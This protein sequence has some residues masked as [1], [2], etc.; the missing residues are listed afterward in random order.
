M[1]GT[2]DRELFYLIARENAPTIWEEA[3]RA[4]SLAAT[5]EDS[6]P[7]NN[8]GFLKEPHDE[9]YPCAWI[10][11]RMRPEARKAILDHVNKALEENGYP[12]AGR[13]INYSVYGSGASYNWDEDGDFD[14]QMWVDT[15]KFNEGKDEPMTED[16]LV[17]DI[18]RIVQLVN[19]PSFKE[20]GL[21][22]EKSDGNMLIQYYAKPGQGTKEENLASKPYACFDLETEDWYQKPEPITPDFYGE[23]FILLEPKAKDIAMQASAV[24]ESLE[25]NIVEWSFWS[26]MYE[27][28]SDPRF[29]SKADDARKDAER[30]KE[31]AHN[32]FL[33]VFQGRAKAYSPEGEGYN[34]ERDLMEKLLEVW[35]IFQRLRHAVK[36]A[37]PWEEQEL[38]NELPTEEDQTPDGEANTDPEKESKSKQSKKSLKPHWHIVAAEPLKLAETIHKI[39]KDG[40]GTFN[41][42]LSP[43]NYQDGYYASVYGYNQTVSVDDFGEAS[44]QGYLDAVE[45]HPDYLIGAWV[46]DGIV[47]LDL[48]KHIPDRGE[49]IEFG[50]YNRQQAIWDIVKDEAV[51]LD[52]ASYEP[53]PAF[54]K[55][56]AWKDLMEKAK[57]LK[58]QGRVHILNNQPDHVIGRVE[59]DHGTYTTQIW[60]QDPNSRAITMW[61]CECPW[62]QYAWQRTRQWKK[63]EGRPCSHTLALFWTAQQTAAQQPQVSPDQM[64]LPGMGQ[65]PTVPPPAPYQPGAPY[66]PEGLPPEQLPHPGTEPVL[67]RGPWEPT[68]QQPL[69]P[70]VGPP[71][72]PLAPGAQPVP[73][74]MQIDPRL[75]R[76]APG[77][78]V[79]PRFVPPATPSGTSHPQEQEEGGNFGFPGAFSKVTMAER[80]GDPELDALIEGFIQKNPTLHPPTN[81]PWKLSPVQVQD[82]QDREKAVNTCS[83]AA[84]SFRA[85]LRE[86][87][88]FAEVPAATTP[89]WDIP[90]D[91]DDPGLHCAV[92][93]HRPRGQTYM[94]D[95]SSRQFPDVQEWPLVM[96]IAPG[97]SYEQWEGRDYPGFGEEGDHE[98]GELDPYGVWEDKWSMR[99]SAFENGTIVRAE[100]PLEGVD[101]DGRQWRVPR[102]SKGEVLSSDE[103][104]TIAIFPLNTGPLEPHLVRVNAETSAFSQSH[105]KP[106]IGR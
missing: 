81:N 74:G 28:H 25:R 106:F 33:N 78:Q 23:W 83:L 30:D 5:V 59:G 93:I 73:Q 54:S 64:Q 40:G 85:Y 57:R 45:G 91:F 7:A 20:L 43:S 77:G 6:E 55:V 4:V 13:F 36:E 84:E 100:Q 44:L 38:P 3:Q 104:V 15:D 97:Q 75:L 9:L 88:M 62:D 17:A 1:T 89:Y 11:Q 86:H 72:A 76:N 31:G 69:V 66:P 52:P 48:T 92:V 32:M 46:N 90:G 21:A 39:L 60:R 80:S 34:D 27:N 95:F 35:G 10:G 16:D 94:I 41:L 53:A 87:G 99:I 19:F 101:R 63:Y 8:F 61:D 2:T 102:N 67:P 82:L 47:Y 18:R 70:P 105:G 103:D 50:I 22:N 24:L 14:M 65:S 51:D 58:D 29:K 71:G 56:A 42:D 12:D 68:P 37:L 96:R 98:Y 26:Q 49:A 79:D